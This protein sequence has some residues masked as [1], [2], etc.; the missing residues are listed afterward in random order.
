MDPTKDFTSGGN[1]LQTLF[2]EIVA[3]NE[4]VHGSFPCAT[5]TSRT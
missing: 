5:D 1:Q 2:T 3:E 4:E